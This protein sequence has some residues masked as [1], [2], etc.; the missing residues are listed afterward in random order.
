MFPVFSDLILATVGV[1]GIV[2]GEAVRCCWC[3]RAKAAA[4]TEAADRGEEGIMPPTVVERR[5]ESQWEEDDL[6]LGWL[7]RKI[8]SVM[9]M[10]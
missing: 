7:R 2:R 5:G 10:A 1:M 9:D 6:G 8:K 3:W 4:A